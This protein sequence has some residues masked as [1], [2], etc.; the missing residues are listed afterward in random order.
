M[1]S[2]YCLD[3]FCPRSLK[4]EF[5][6]ILVKV[7]YPP[8]R[9]TTLTGWGANCWGQ[10][11]LRRNYHPKILGDRI[12][13]RDSKK[14][15]TTFVN[16]VKYNQYEVYMKKYPLRFKPNKPS[17]ITTHTRRPVAIQQ[18]NPSQ[19]RSL[20]SDRARAKARSLRSDRARAK[21]RSLCS[22]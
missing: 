4:C 1:G 19:A 2:E 17:S 8:A 16:F 12:S 18:P 5:R 14:K 10:K 6:P 7:I 21:V 22:D 20:R 9:V 11:W 13:E 15:D 3:N